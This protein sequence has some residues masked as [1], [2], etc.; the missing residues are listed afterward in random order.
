M[1]NV[2]Y[3]NVVNPPPSLRQLEQVHAGAA[4]VVI[5]TEDFFENEKVRR[6]RR[7]LVTLSAWLSLY[8]AE[9]HTAV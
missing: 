8:D 7:A 1:V 2:W 9:M 3:P 5:S 6:I 4:A